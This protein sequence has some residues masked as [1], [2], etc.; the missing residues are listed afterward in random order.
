[1]GLLVLDPDSPTPA[2]EQIRAQIAA[3]IEDGS[4]S[5]AVQL[6]TVRR[7]ASDLGLA[8][9]TVA[10]AY[11]ELELAGLIETRGRHGTFVAGSPS[12][13]RELAVE[14]A[15]TFLE[16][17]QELGISPAETSALLRREAEKVGQLRWEPTT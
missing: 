5:R 7:L 6:P 8:V 9:N 14:A 10:R 13:P 11:R 15:R 2:Y 3:A 16:Q 12:G 17:M 1:V 4:L